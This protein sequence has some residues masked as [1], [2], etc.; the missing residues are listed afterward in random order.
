MKALINVN[1]FNSIINH[2]TH[3][4]MHKKANIIVIFHEVFLRAQ[5][6]CNEHSTLEKLSGKV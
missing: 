4:H 1:K 2:L 5:L 3:S 6:L